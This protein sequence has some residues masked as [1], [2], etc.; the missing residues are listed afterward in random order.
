MMS[1]RGCPCSY[2]GMNSKLCTEFLLGGAGFFLHVRVRDDLV[3]HVLQGLL[4]GT[5]A[6]H[7]RIQGRTGTRQIPRPRLGLRL[8]MKGGHRCE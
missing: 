8:S 7:A 2:L 4:T 1:R 6:C 3:P 5:M